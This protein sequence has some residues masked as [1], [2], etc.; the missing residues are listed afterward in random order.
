MVSIWGE[1]ASLYIWEHLTS[2]QHLKTNS[3]TPSYTISFSPFPTSSLSS[4]QA[5][6]EFLISPQQVT[7]VKMQSKASFNI[8]RQNVTQNINICRKHKFDLLTLIWLMLY[9][10]FVDKMQEELEMS[11][12]NSFGL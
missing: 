11:G 3:I 4:D 1:V 9:I 8:S 5:D 7:L 6:V 12:I 2:E 10:T